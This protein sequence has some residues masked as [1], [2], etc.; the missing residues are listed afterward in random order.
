MLLVP[1]RRVVHDGLVTSF[2]ATA[3]LIQ[4]KFSNFAIRYKTIAFHIMLFNKETYIE[5]RQA[6][7]KRL[8]SGLVLLFGNNDSPS[9][10][11]SNSYRFRQDSSF[12]YFYGQHREGLVGVIDIDADSWATTSAS[13]TSYGLAR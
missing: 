3:E 4:I 13:T 8:G 12:L 1:G 7:K 9:N 2:T 10:Y 6:L 11:P 5:R